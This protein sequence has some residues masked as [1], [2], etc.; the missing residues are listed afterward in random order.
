MIME[1]YHSCILQPPLQCITDCQIALFGWRSKNFISKVIIND[2][3]TWNS[4]CCKDVARCNGV[5]YTIRLYEN[6]QQFVKKPRRVRRMRIKSIPFLRGRVPR[7]NTG[8]PLAY[9]PS[10]KRTACT[11]AAH[12]SKRMPVAFALRVSPWAIP[13]S[14]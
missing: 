10:A 9:R 12:N 2:L 1:S 13:L 7:K 6:S 8:K 5:K 11:R 14:D 3:I 4:L